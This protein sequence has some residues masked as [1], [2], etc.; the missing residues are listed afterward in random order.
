MLNL[1]SNAIKFTPCGGNIK[2]IGKKVRCVGDLS[3]KDSKL[4][5]VINE[6]EGSIFLEI[7]VADKGIGIKKDDIPKLFKLFGFLDST[8]QLNTK[9]I[10]LGLHI[11]KKITNMFDGDIACSSNLGQGSNFVFLVALNQNI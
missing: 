2:I 11:T 4:I 1:V 7:Q 8:K 9:G 3:I 6:N 10:G 5:E